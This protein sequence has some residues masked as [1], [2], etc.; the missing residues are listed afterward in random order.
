[1]AKY[2]IRNENYRDELVKFSYPFSEDSTLVSNDGLVIGTDLVLDAILYFKQDVSLPVHISSIDGTAGEP[3]DFNLI[4]SDTTGNIVAR[5]I[6]V[7][8][9]EKATILNNED[10]ECGFLVITEQ[11][12]N[13]FSGQVSGKVIPLFNDVARFGLDVCSVSKVDHL[14]YV[15]AGDSYAS[16]VVR[17]VARHGVRWS[18][19]EDGVLSL[20]VVA[21]VPEDDRIPLTSVNGVE[22]GSIWLNHHP[23]ANI[24]IA[25]VNGVLTFIAAGDD[26]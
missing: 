14:R 16:D 25:V 24:R 10:V 26:T 8:G 6:V 4:L 11:G 18:L 5:A 3:A 13:R 9:N 2:G 20:D 17:I 22:N 12:F 7:Q 1:M 15:A 19:S 23:T 21:D